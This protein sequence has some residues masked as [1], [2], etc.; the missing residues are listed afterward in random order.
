MAKKNLIDW[1][2]VQGY[3]QY[4]VDE[5]E[6]IKKK[7]RKKRFEQYEKEDAWTDFSAFEDGYQFGDVSK[8]ILGTGVKT[9][10]NFT[11]GLQSNLEGLLDFGTNVASMG[12]E[13]LGYDEATKKLR[14]FAQKDFIAE[15]D[16]VNKAIINTNPILS[17][18]NQ[19]FSAYDNLKNGYDP[20]D[21]L[22]KNNQLAT[23]FKGQGSL[24]KGLDKI[25]SNSIT[26]NKLDSLTQ[27]VGQIAGQ[28][29]L[30]SAGLPWQVTAFANSA[31]NE[32]N[33]AFQNNATA[34]Q[35]FLSGLISGAVEVGT[36]Y[37]GGGANKLLGMESL[38]SK[39][40]AKL[41]SKISNKLASR[42][43]KIGIDASSEGL[44][45]VLSGLGT[46]IG[47]KLTYM[48]DKELEELYS[49]DQALDDFI[50]GALG[51]VI[52]NVPGQVQSVKRGEN[53]FSGLTENEQT[54]LDKVIEE[55]TKEAQKDGKELSKKELKKIEDQAIKDLQEGNLTTAE[56]D[57]A[58]GDKEV[59]VD[60]KDNYLRR[61]IENERTEFKLDNDE[62]KNVKSDKQ[63]ALFESTKGINNSTLTHRLFK[64]LNAIQGVN[65]TQQYKMTTTQGLYEMGIVQKDANG[66][67]VMPDGSPYVPRGLNYKDGVIYVN[68]DVGTQSATQAMY[69]EVFE[70][71]KKAAP[72]EYN[73]FKQ[74]VR[75]IVG[76]DAIK[77]EEAK[78]TKMYGEELTDDIRD[79]IINDKFGEIAESEDF[80][81]RIANDRTMFEKFIDAI[82]RVVNYIKGTPEEKELI[83]LKNNLEKKFA[84]AYKNTDFSQ[85]KEVDNT[86]FSNDIRYS[87]SD[88]DIQAK[89]N[90]SMTM[91][92]AREMLQRAFVL[93][94][95]QDYS[96]GAVNNIDEWVNNDDWNYQISMII[97]SNQ[98]LYNKYIASNEGINNDEYTLDDVIEAYKNGTLTG[99]VKQDYGRV[100]T[101]INT[102]YIDDSFYSP[103]QIE[104]TN[105][106]YEKANQRVTKSNKDE[107]YKARADFIIAAH[108]QNVSEQLGI[109]AK[110][111]NSKLKSWANY[112]SK[113]LEL[114]KQLN[115]NVSNQ[116]KWSGL[117]NSSIVND[118][119]IT[120]DQLESMVKQVIGK[121]NSNGWKRKYITSAMLALD[122]HIDYKNLTFDFEQ[123][124]KLQ[125]QHAAG[126][127]NNRTNVIR[128]GSGYQNTV[129]HEM[130]HYID[131]QWAR[132]LF[133]NENRPLSS[134][135]RNYNQ[136]KLTQEQ[137][138]FIEHF[139]EFQNDI[140]TKAEMGDTLKYGTSKNAS[141]WQ[142]PT[143]TFA[144]FVGKFTEWV[145]NQATNNR[146]GYEEKH[147]TDRFTEN[148]Y[149]EFVK[150]L[151]EKSAL[152]TTMEKR[153]GTYNQDSIAVMDSITPEQRAELK[154]AFDELDNEQTPS[155]Q[156]TERIQDIIGK[157]NYYK[158]SNEQLKSIAND[159]QFSLT[160]NQNITPQDI[161]PTRGWDVRGRDIA[162][163]SAIAP[164]QEQVQQLQSTIEDLRDNIAPLREEEVENLP[165]NENVE[166]PTRYNLTRQES[167]RLDFLDRLE[168][169]NMLTEGLAEERNELI[170]KEKNA[171]EYGEDMTPV[172]SLND[173][174]DMDEVARDRSANA[175]QYE[176][177]EVKPYFQEEARVLLA[178]IN[179]VIPGERFMV[180]G[181]DYLH[182]NEWHG[183]KR[184]ASEDVA[185]LLDGYT[186]GSKYTKDQLRE[187]LNAIIEDH[188]LENKAVSKR[189]EFMLDDRLRNG[190][191]TIEGYQ[192]EPNQNYL[193]M[194]REQSWDNYYEQNPWIENVPAE[195]EEPTIMM[196]PEE[197]SRTDNIAPTREWKQIDGKTM[198]TKAEETR[199]EK[200]NNSINT[201][202]E[203]VDNLD[204]QLDA[205][206]SEIEANEKEKAQSPREAWLYDSINE[207]LYNQSSELLAKYD[208]NFAKLQELKDQ[209]E[210]LTD[211]VENT[212]L[213]L[214]QKDIKKALVDEMGITIADL[215]TGKHINTFNL[216]RTDSKRVAEKIFEPEIAKKVNEATVDKVKHNEAERTR[217]LNNERQE[218]KDLGI[219][220]RSK[221]S[222]LVQKYGE[223][224]ITEAELR[225]QVDNKTA[226]KIIK[227]ANI[228]RSKYDMYI[229]QINNTITAMGYDA[230]PKR[231][232]YMRHFQELSDKFTE[233]GIPFN[234]GDLISEEL[235]TDINGRTDE[236]RP[237]KNWFASA[238]Q[239]KG[240]KTTYD[241]ITGIDGYLEGASNLIYHTEDI[242]RYRALSDFIREVYGQKEFDKLEGL[243]ESEVK[244]RISLIQGNHLSQY[245]AWLDEQANTLAN[246][247]SKLDRGFEQYAGRKAY[248]IMNT[249][250]KQVGSN[251]TGFNVSSALT[252]FISS[253][254]AAGKTSKLALLKGTMST[255]GNM[256]HKDGFVNKSDFLTNRFGSDMISQKM[257]QKLS[258][259]GQ[260]FMKGS[261]YLTANLIVRSKYYEGLSKGMNETQA[262]KYA[263]D[264]GSRVLGDRSKGA[265]ASI[266][267]SKTL[268]LFTQF[269][270]ETNNQL[271]YLFHDAK[272]DYKTYEGSKLGALAKVT[273]Q[274][275]QIFAY[276]YLYNQMF[277]AIAGRRPAFDPIEIMKT[278][279]GFG[280]DDDEEDEDFFSRA[281]KA[282]DM[283]LDTLPFTSILD[284]RI[285]IREVFEIFPDIEGA[286]TGQ[287]KDKYGNTLTRE[288]SRKNVLEDLAY[289]LPTGGGQLKK[290]IK[291]AKQYILPEIDS[292]N[293]P[294]AGSY[295]DKGNLRFEADESPWGI[296]QSLLFGEWASK[297][298]R[299]YVE[300]GF[301]TTKKQD[302]GKSQEEKGQSDETIAKV[303]SLGL[304]SEEKADYYSTKK[305][306]TN[307]KK[308]YKDNDDY[309]GKKSS[310]IN[311]ILE[312]DLPDNAKIELYN[313]TYKDK[314][315]QN[316]VN[317]GIKADD[318]LNF[319][320]QTFT[321][322]KDSNGKSIS[323]SKKQK[324]FDYIN[325]MNIP[326]EQKII[327]AKT[328]Y[329]TYNEYNQEV[330]DYLNKSNLS[331]NEKTDVLEELGFK[332]DGDNVSW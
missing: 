193:E 162:L 152:D 17:L 2:N 276:S 157:D 266:F 29:A 23:L 298:A 217:F 151:Q 32:M 302:I 78:Y 84:E 250:K 239:R 90:Q 249:L 196:T 304:N 315:A 143:E 317:A 89:I 190:Y 273:F 121:E 227:A 3:S 305:D 237:G 165:I 91:D 288:Q 47:Q 290:T 139:R 195:I 243:S 18:L 44:E 212:P 119:S 224:L 306:I 325:S 255:I 69:H 307:V 231:Q 155:Y 286:I 218:I 60:K 280:D 256:F 158:L 14:N 39:G 117:E 110:E 87:L 131:Y 292:E 203:R 331:Y 54:I 321:A 128:I 209:Q 259:A 73:N 11:K 245:A 221:E 115:E 93:S 50:M 66:N 316:Y 123:S 25:A 24:S 282:K 251:M 19:G 281:G 294:V 244:K 228:L 7:E 258:N 136:E 213:K 323:G 329:P 260:L 156:L 9:G 118:V 327:L 278:L 248:T 26:G 285:P 235:P 222:E 295:T 204:K 236:F 109:D 77:Q 105:E 15:N 130:G 252:N 126:D 100:D 312:S 88:N 97:D 85:N 108:N 169:E 164:L 144:R 72:T 28:A 181:R 6:N 257:W 27:T 150:I 301:K 172:E 168:R 80:L 247:K 271:D 12:T 178:E 332:V 104:A 314:N 191:E 43:L 137:I 55:R 167:Q 318:Y 124:S 52:T 107:V 127:Y 264:F 187:G 229:D 138:K 21:L 36:E 61:I 40:L 142:E 94:D 310:I 13:A 45:E 34:G 31:G 116:N 241:A 170:A 194:L 277:E 238:L 8:A 215:D 254:I 1:G 16:F 268:G 41:G 102:N 202:Q 240:N 324:V 223:K 192:I 175:Y 226:D 180:E 199:L 120:D 99:N 216:S 154:R 79:E 33:N 210:K 132:E 198:H 293:Y 287:Q 48:N 82:K 81:N 140:E 75:D 98:D 319:K 141:Y 161:A 197:I 308:E 265:T 200:I 159:T 106:L 232:D 163:E 42:L 53:A 173:V 64:T 113:T 101:S 201:L 330:V 70:G 68:A 328:M 95:I 74:M 272:M 111:L 49:K 289:L 35:A 134:I 230:I 58:V 184:Q 135:S 22:V 188:G 234:R 253:T 261:D 270:L 182:P 206:D 10:Q 153:Y 56:M 189:L 242:Q 246:K 125:E 38:G 148:Q 313:E 62:S 225:S 311:E 129:A 176:H 146:Y 267:N 76:E 214:K 303:N 145:K 149:K 208:K 46:A 185:N 114:S 300:S 96:D 296:T 183:Y 51:T 297:N 133:G 37:I 291:G 103:Q 122:T 65:N 160:S 67:Y 186:L 320:S 59:N 71:F 326:F 20:G 86:S 299:E 262:M 177:P 92:E 112:P 5:Y 179:E 83:K 283:L 274:A 284:G 309:A 211:K 30:G 147:Y 57:R 233:W 220:A 174:R 63:K 207:E 275:G 279:F 205:L 166:P 322:D 171:P 219:K 269:Q 263:D 4:G